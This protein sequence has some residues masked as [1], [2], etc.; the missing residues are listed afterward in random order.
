MNYKKIPKIELHRHLEGSVR[1]S[2]IADEARKQNLSLPYKDLSALK[3]KCQ[4]LKPMNTLMD[5]INVFWA[6]QSILGTTE[7]IQRITFELIEDAYNDGIR[8]LEIR[9]SP[10]FLTTDHELSFSEALMAIEAGIAQSR[11]RYDIQ[12]G[13]I[14]IASR[15]FPIESAEKTLD[16]ALQFRNS[17]IGFDLADDEKE[18]DF[19]AFSKVTN[20]AKDQGL[21][22]SIHSGE[23]IGTEVNV[24][25]TIE[26]LGA[27]RI[28]HGVQ[29]IRDE[30]VLA[31]VVE[32]GAVLEICP[33]SNYLTNAVTDLR[34]HPAKKLI[35]A[36][37]PICINSDDPGVFAI[38]L[39]N[40]YR[41]C[42][43][44]LG[45]S[46]DDFQACLQNALMASFL[47]PDQKKY[48]HKKYFDFLTM[49]HI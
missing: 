10:E 27:S 4:V 2:T 36:G 14:A 46:K 3:E 9:Y 39:S 40:E 18:L 37:V 1:L 15:M 44:M 34:L 24:M 47:D 23:E 5:V 35:Q 49:E 29:I 16:H 45:F 12:V 7:A 19:E 22:I 17:F 31:K 11:A 21:G 20:R 28:G 42:M 43:E 32:A 33:T 6:T 26:K 48:L 13:L 41:V 25:P 8:A 38:D 30:E